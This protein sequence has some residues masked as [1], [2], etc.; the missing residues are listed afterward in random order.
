MVVERW[1]LKE[2]RKRRRTEEEEAEE[3]ERR[4]TGSK[5]KNHTKMWGK[6]RF[7]EAL[8]KRTFERKIRSAKIGKI[9]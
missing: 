8:F 1:W 6:G 9:C 5:T 7:F 4:D 2:R 3:D